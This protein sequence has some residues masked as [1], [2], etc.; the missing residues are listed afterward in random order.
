MSIENKIHAVL[1]ELAAGVMR[2][3]GSLFDTGRW[4]RAVPAALLCAAVVAAAAEPARAETAVTGVRVSN[5]RGFT[6]LTLT[7]TG[8]V[9]FRAATAGAPYRLILELEPVD[10]RLSRTV[11]L[12]GGLLTSL[13]F[14]PGEQEARIIGTLRGPAKVQKTFALRPRKGRSWRLVI[15][16]ER[17][18]KD[19]FDRIHAARKRKAAATRQT[20]KA[21]PK[22]NTGP[23]SKHGEK[24]PGG[25]G[26]VIAGPPHGRLIVIDPG[27]GGQDTGAISPWG[28]REKVVALRFAR[29]LRRAL[30]ATKRFRVRLTRDDDT[31]LPLRRR[32]EIARKARADL[33]VS[34]HA[35]SNPYHRMHGLS[36][37]TLS[38][39]AS[40]RIAAHRE[41]RADLIAGVNLEDKSD[42]VSGI[43][44]DLVRR[45]TMTRSLRIAELVVKEGRKVTAL[46]HKPHRSAGFAVLKA[47]EVPSI[48]V[49]LGVLTNR[50]DESKL[51]DAAH[52]RRVAAAMV[53]AI[54]RFFAGRRR[55]PQTA[56]SGRTRRK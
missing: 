26:V 45:E 23:G 39:R 31:F 44:I 43:L 52:H 25:R 54:D 8:A 37:Y 38:A 50:A 55:P 46:L 7:L 27:H 49:E 28:L 36:V 30:L 3:F 21:A 41:N 33:F 6:R 42:P 29:T 17:I 14:E 56:A 11:R 53:R 2:G 19:A 24:T 18:S 22:T 9:R 32:Y 5:H 51:R 12:D 1:L 47:P 48:L 4:R 13:R 34:I 40:D 20:A 16:L 35:D 10:W 15:D